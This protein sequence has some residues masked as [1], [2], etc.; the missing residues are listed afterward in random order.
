MTRRDG[1]LALIDAAPGPSSASTTTPAR[2]AES[3]AHSAAQFAMTCRFA[4][5]TGFGRMLGCTLVALSLVGSLMATN[6]W[7]Q[8]EVWMTGSAITTSGL[9]RSSPGASE[10]TTDPGAGATFSRTRMTS[11]NSSSGTANEQPVLPTVALSYAPEGKQ[12]KMPFHYEWRNAEANRSLSIKATALTT[13]CWSAADCAPDWLIVGTG[14][15]GTSSL[16]A[17]LVQHPQLVPAR[18]KEPN[19][20]G[21]HTNWLHRTSYAKRLFPASGEMRLGEQLGEASPYY[22]S[23][24]VAPSQMRYLAPR[25]KI[26]M[27]LRAPPSHCWSAS[28]AHARLLTRNGPCHVEE[29]SAA[30]ILSGYYPCDPS[31][32]L[33]SVQRWLDHF[34]AEQLLVLLF[35]SFVANRRRTL[36]AAR[37]FLR[38][39]PFDFDAMLTRGIVAGARNRHTKAPLPSAIRARLASC[40]S[41][42]T[43]RLV[44][45]LEATVGLGI[46]EEM[47]RFA[48]WRE[49]L[50]AVAPPPPVAAPAAAPVVQTHKQVSRQHHGFRAPAASFE[51]P[52]VGV[53]MHTY[54]RPPPP[55]LSAV[56]DNVGCYCAATRSCTL[57]YEHSLREVVLAPGER[58]RVPWYSAPLVMNATQDGAALNRPGWPLHQFAK[59]LQMAK[60]WESPDSPEWLWFIDGDTRIL[61][62]ST[63]I[64]TFLPEDC[65]G[66]DGCEDIGLVVVDHPWAG[67]V[68][69]SFLVRRS[70]AGLAI[71][72]DLWECQEHRPP[73]A[74][75]SS[76]ADALMVRTTPRT[77]VAPYTRHHCMTSSAWLMGGWQGMTQCWNYQMARMGHPYGHRRTSGVRYIDPAGPDFQAFTYFN[78][79]DRDD[80]LL[81]VYGKNEKI[82][83]SRHVELPLDQSKHDIVFQRGD[84]LVHSSLLGGARLGVPDLLDAPGALPG[85][86]LRKSTVQTDAPAVGRKP[87]PSDAA[88]A[89][90]ACRLGPKVAYERRT[91][92]GRPGTTAEIFV[93]RRRNRK[94]PNSRA[95][96]CEQS[97]PTVMEQ[98][99]AQ[100]HLP[101]LG[102]ATAA[103]P[104]H[105]R[106]IA[107]Q[108]A[109]KAYERMRA[110]GVW[111]QSHCPLPLGIRRAAEK[112]SEIGTACEPWIHRGI[113][114]V[115]S[116]LLDDD[117]H[118]LEWS[119][120]SSSM[121]YIMLV[122]SLHSI[123]HDAKWARMVRE[124]LRARLPARMSKVWKLSAISN[125]TP[126]GKAAG[127]KLGT[128]ESLEAFR[129]YVNARLRRSDFDFVSVDGR[130]RSA[131]LD[132]VWHENLVAPGGLLLLDNSLRAAYRK[133]RAPFDAAWV[134]VEFNAT[135]TVHPEAASALW[136]RSK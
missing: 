23:N 121:Y 134:R 73:L 14:Q 120:G 11:R 2:A 111:E 99:R 69:G 19:F 123:E 79:G 72:R 109:A 106:C 24:P 57:F 90:D 5:M 74:E 10:S 46:G 38:V 29:T 136:C 30:R 96:K 119:T 58:V 51:R 43:R 76:L 101:P 129:N 21:L 66:S 113:Q 125:S 49:V 65:K 62:F 93:G 70:P 7:P 32:Y 17:S 122:A 13:A 94:C 8:K 44:N 127:Q 27:V 39:A 68:T 87:S 35:E 37:H 135:E 63:R 25:A 75:Q 16:Y 71:L 34:P 64:D 54:G 31:H 1:K 103:K 128:D 61:N 114:F 9:L 107:M 95:I 92:N 15:A 80:A 50:D 4:N 82:D 112:P 84:L 18:E 83:S 124:N 116:R 88:A 3:D 98:L 12:L 41:E 42:A 110:M 100:G 36:E 52:R 130:A 60:V 132:R 56:A 97:G 6:L 33:V 102:G 67:I 53:V 47:R 89:A 45:L 48:E 85:L 133:T 55:G 104:M 22:I 118:A 131:C 126:Y 20:V 40:H 108:R 117:M 78:Y 26:I 115:L 91:L 105:F 81:N 86:S 77:G 59:L 28:A